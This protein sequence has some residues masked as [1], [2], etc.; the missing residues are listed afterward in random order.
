MPK[1]DQI[2]VN[3]KDNPIEINHNEIFY[4][5]KQPF[6]LEVKVKKLHKRC[7]KPTHTT[8]KGLVR[9]MKK[10]GGKWLR[11]D[12]PNNRPQLFGFMED[13]DKDPFKYFTID[14]TI[15]HKEKIKPGKI[16]KL[17]TIN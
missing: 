14:A 2:I 6:Q 5:G 15:L 11:A 13:T 1:L 12:N 4:K 8:I 17:A 16:I 9:S 7:D 3:L 10:V